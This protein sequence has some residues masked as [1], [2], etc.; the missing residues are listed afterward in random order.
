MKKKLRE[1]LE[2]Y[3][4]VEWIEHV[5]DEETNKIAT[6]ELIDQAETEIRKWAIDKLSEKWTRV[7]YEGDKDKKQ[8]FNQ[9]RTQA[10]KALEDKDEIKK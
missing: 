4:S 5:S 3:I 8:G 1:I 6:K 10:K 7:M 9:A 2:N